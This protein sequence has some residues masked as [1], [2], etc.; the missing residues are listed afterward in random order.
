VDTVHPHRSLTK[1]CTRELAGK[2]PRIL[3]SAAYAFRS[4]VMVARGPVDLPEQDVRE[5]GAERAG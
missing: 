3:L 5:V 4:L 2:P 1:R